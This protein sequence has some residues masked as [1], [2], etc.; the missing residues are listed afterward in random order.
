MEISFFRFPSSVSK[1]E[2]IAYLLDLAFEN[3][4]PFFHRLLK[5]SS[6]ASSFQSYLG[7]YL[8]R[9]YPLSS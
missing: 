7:S 2:L 1:F 5:H 9:V 3:Q 6:K 8:S 4:I